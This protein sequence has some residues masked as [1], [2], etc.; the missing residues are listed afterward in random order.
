MRFEVEDTGCGISEEDLKR[1]T[2]PYVRVDSKEAW[3]GGTGVELAVCR[4][5]VDAMG[6][7]LSIVSALGKGST[8]TVV[9]RNVEVSDTAPEDEP[10]PAPNAP[11]PKDVASE[12][13]TPNAPVPKADVPKADAAKT[14]HPEPAADLKGEKTEESAAPRRILIADDQKMNQLVLNAMLKKLGTFDVVMAKD[15]QEALD[16]LTSSDAPF[17]LVLTDMWMPVMDGEGLVR[18]IRANEKLASIPVHVVTADTE[19]QGRFS[20]AGFNGILL[21]PV[22]V[23]KLKDVVK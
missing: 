11:A 20:E 13:A 12:T 10:S 4:K 6:G 16:I 15:G 19:M 18:A 21:K 22:T 3:H 23:D 2:S 14:A 8:F 7:E 1:I 17:D 5:L 9:L